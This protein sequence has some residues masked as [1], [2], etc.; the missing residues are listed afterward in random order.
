[1]RRQILR[2]LV[3]T[4]RAM[5]TR[6][7]CAWA[8][9]RA[10]EILRWH[11]KSVRRAADAVADRVGW[12]LPGGIVWALKPEIHLSVAPEAGTGQRRESVRWRPSLKNRDLA[13]L[14]PGEPSP[15]SSHAFPVHAKHL[16]CG[17][18]T[19]FP[20]GERRDCHHRAFDESR[21]FFADHALRFGL[22]QSSSGGE[23]GHSGRNDPLR[24]KHE[25]R[26]FIRH[27][28]PRSERNVVEAAHGN[29]WPEN[30]YLAIAQMR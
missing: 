1:V 9:P 13:P 27:T 12:R 23:T 6:E 30:F 2:V 26:G 10:R 14:G 11:L 22:R 19:F 5:S 29:A 7:L 25:P 8:Y 28:E 4:G 15:V 17:N 21:R 24:L 18:R 3:S 16:P 20:A